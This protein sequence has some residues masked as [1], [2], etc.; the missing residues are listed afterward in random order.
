M[1][2]Q[3]NTS[4]GFYTYVHCR[5][6]GVPFYVG[7]G[8]GR[9]AYDFTSNRNVAFKRCIAKYGVRNIETRIYSADSENV[10]IAREISLIAQ[11]RQ[12]GFKLHNF[13]NG[14]DGISGFTWSPNQIRELKE[15]RLLDVRRDFRRQQS[16]E[17]MI[18]HNPMFNDE[19]RLKQKINVGIAVRHE[20]VRNK[21]R[22]AK[23]GNDY[24]K[25]Y[26]WVNNG[27]KCNLIPNDATIPDGFRLGRLS[28]RKWMT[29]GVVEKLVHQKDI[30]V[31]LIRGYNFG[32]L[33]LL[34]CNK[35]Q[36]A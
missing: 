29:D 33:V 2:R 35:E 12:M 32:R 30:P 31:F 11:F 28:D 3:D 22:L 17:Q 20:D 8:T 14:G 19:V 24:T 1:V 23:L 25:G 7:K 27:E 26:R 16:R 15:S 5:P 21:Q 13:T 4:S 34:T 10:A 9:R 18:R 6:N 36:R